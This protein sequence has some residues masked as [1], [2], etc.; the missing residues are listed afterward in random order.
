MF[1]RIPPET[2]VQKLQNHAIDKGPRV[3]AMRAMSEIVNGNPRVVAQREMIDAASHT[4]RV[5][6]LRAT[7]AMM[8][9]ANRAIRQSGQRQNNTGLSDQLK[10]GIES[11]SGISMDH[12]KVHYNS[13][14]PAQLNAHAFAQGRDI[15]LAPGQE[16]HLPHEAW[17]VVQQAQGRV[18]ATR[19]MK[20]GV[21]INDDRGLEREADAMGRR[22]LSAGGRAPLTDE[23]IQA[24]A[25]VAQLAR[26]MTEEE[27]KNFKDIA[28]RLEEFGDVLSHSSS[29]PPRLDRA[30]FP[31]F[32]QAEALAEPIHLSEEVEDGTIGNLAEMMAQLDPMMD[33]AMERAAE[34]RA[35][36]ER[37]LY[38]PDKFEGVRFR[39]ENAKTRARETA[40]SLN[41]RLAPL[42]NFDRNLAILRKNPNAVFYVIGQS[43]MGQGD[44]AF[45]VR[46]VA[47]LRRLGFTAIGVQ[48]KNSAFAPGKSHAEASSFITPDEMIAH[49]K[50]R[51]FIIEGPL[52]DPTPPPLQSAPTPSEAPT[53][54]KDT[55][56][57]F[58]VDP[59]SILNLRL[60]EYGTLTYRG[61][62]RQQQKGA[63]TANVV[64]HAGDPRHAF[65]G[66][67]HGEIGAFYNA[68]DTGSGSSLEAALQD[69][70]G[71]HTCQ[72][73][74]AE[75]GER[76]N[77]DIFV[78]YANKREA[79]QGWCQAVAAVAGARGAIIVGIYGEAK[80]ATTFR[81]DDATVTLIDD[82]TKSHEPREIG[83]GRPG[84]RV[85]VTNS[86]PSRAL[87]ALQKRAKPFTLTTGNYSLSEAVERGHFPVY[88]TLDF[89]AGVAGALQLQMANALE[90][91]GLAGTP[92]GNAMLKVVVTSDL[93][94]LTAEISLI[95]AHPHEV[96][97][98]TKVIKANTD[99]KETLVARLAELAELQE[100]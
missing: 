18:P 77:A 57:G 79:V 85:I 14:L 82:K 61:G 15:H 60:Y 58:R 3:A 24:A 98:V 83:R 31:L 70:P 13:S 25:T 81:I 23:V 16:R 78:G 50:S 34:D 72:M 43:A 63:E 10:T 93:A 96:A 66:M 99:I 49:A 97:L 27:A 87:N 33:A 53:T 69:E 44:T 41:E 89:N 30:F 94:K 11:L 52:S 68:E 32:A 12:V 86:V 84:T 64:D 7:T 74:L 5:A 65:M 80:L 54:H 56:H 48:Q 88:E 4:G 46:T 2:V 47:L 90:R 40:Q 67:G 62:Q 39:D 45:I 8:N 75:I 17:H 95:L 26:G 55:L 59:R 20:G 6:E 1:A 42:T 91:L 51:D 38:R 92:L 29:I 19:Q 37:G 28:K 100:R 22:A 9:G 21:A 73:L 76:P 71:N 35:A 36:T